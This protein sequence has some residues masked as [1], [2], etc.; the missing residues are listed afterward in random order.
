[1]AVENDEELKELLDDRNITVSSS[2]RELLLAADDVEEAVQ[3]VEER[4]AGRLVITASNIRDVVEVDLTESSSGEESKD[5]ADNED[6]DDDDV[7]E[8]E[9][10]Y[11]EKVRDTY[12]TWVNRET[13]NSAEAFGEVSEDPFSDIEEVENGFG[14]ERE[15]DEREFSI[16]E[17]V[18]SNSEA[19]GEIE[20]F[21]AYFRSRYE[22]LS[23]ILKQRLSPKPI[24][25]LGAG[26]H[27]DSITVIGMVVDK[28]NTSSG[29]RLLELEDTTGTTR[30][31]FS[32]EEEIEICDQIVNDGVIGVQG[33]LSDDGGI[34]FGDRIH[35]PE[36]PPRRRTRTADRDVKVALISDVHFGARE[37]AVDK[38]NRFVEWLH[39]Q[40]DIE[41]LLIAGDIIEG[42]GIYNGQKEQLSV[43]T[44]ERQYDLCQAAFEQLPDDITVVVTPGNHDGVPQAEPQPTFPEKYRDRFPDNIHFGP[45]PAV[46]DIEGVNFLMYHGVSILPFIDLLPNGDVQEPAS[47]MWPMLQKRHIAPMYG[48]GVR[49]SPEREDNLV[50]EEV[51][52]V[53][54]CGHVHTFDLHEY[55]GVKLVNTGAWQHQTDYQRRLD[56]TPDVG[57][58]PVFNLE[59]MSVQL[60]GF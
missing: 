42:V 58:C 34:I 57:F 48:K 13:A 54:H 12:I 55:N 49:I 5:S 7:D 60:Y 29:N 47:G 16:S 4:F 51:P 37:M 17:D 50:I 20:D 3:A 45:N 53:V 2:G 18:A 10:T 8:V 26:S 24:E 15:V 39:E 46:I 38:W 11:R 33:T 21:V 56:I 31:V 28:R 41:Y 35:F 22:R 14:V 19:E 9:E 25:A 30:V 23:G 36:V 1:M 43:Q 52:D 40:E 59:D 6:K 27:S 44:I 32:D